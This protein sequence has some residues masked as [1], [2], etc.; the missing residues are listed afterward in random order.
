MS[1][2]P[3]HGDTGEHHL[4]AKLALVLFAKL[5]SLRAERHGVRKVNVVK[6]ASINV[7]PQMAGSHCVFVF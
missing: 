7:G 2:E 4:V 1:D 3:L 5:S 6:L